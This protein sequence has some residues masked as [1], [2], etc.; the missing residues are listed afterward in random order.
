MRKHNAYGGFQ[1]LEIRYWE[2]YYSPEKYNILKYNSAKAG[3][4]I[5]LKTKKIDKIYVPLYLCPNVLKE[6]EKHNIEVIYYKINMELLPQLHNIPDKSWIYIVDYFGIMDERID[7]YI[8]THCN[9]H[10]ILDNCHSFF[11]LPTVGKNYIYS[12]KK[13][14]GVPDGA[15]VITDEFL[16]EQPEMT[17]GSEYA[18]YLLE[19]LEKGT[20]ACYLRKKQVDKY[21]NN[22][23]GGISKLA[24]LLMKSIDYSKVITS[25]RENARIYNRAFKEINN[26][27]IEDNAI[28]Y[29]YPL[30]I[31]KNIKKNLIE[32]C[33]YV[34]TLWSHCTN[35]KYKGSVEYNLAENTLFLPVD[36]RYDQEDIEYIINLVMKYIG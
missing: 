12:C 8:T 2:E 4:N 21:L 18:N 3:L 29:M 6:I 7:K 22:N 30:N 35:P 24:D 26:L 17:E 5:L 27:S 13:F 10:F 11:H 15:Y 31:K 16:T 33:I 23:Y 19:C 34:P 28:P 20:N 9:M 14:F 36:Q 32:E 25:R 1:P